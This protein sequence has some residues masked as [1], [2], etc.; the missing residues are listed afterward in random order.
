MDPSNK[1]SREL[2]Q[3]IRRELLSQAIF[4]AVDVT[5]RLARTIDLSTGGLSLTLPQ[6]LNNGQTCAITFDVPYDQHRQRALISGRVTS[7]IAREDGS[8]RVGIRFVQADAVS[9]KLI[10]EAVDK[11]LAKDDSK[12]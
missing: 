7:C 3:S 12:V 5:S 1:N 2:R 6:P 10:Q 11:H 9:K 8:Y 4:I